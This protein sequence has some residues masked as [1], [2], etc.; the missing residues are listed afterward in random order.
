M[1]IKAVDIALRI[2]FD[3]GKFYFAKSRDADGTF[4][5]ETETR[6]ETFSLEIETRPRH[7]KFRPRR[8]ETE[9]RRS[10]DE[11]ETRPRR[12]P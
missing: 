11:A 3:N 2:S 6:P 8:D 4:L 5:A 10:R 12:D 9:T 1:R 7:L